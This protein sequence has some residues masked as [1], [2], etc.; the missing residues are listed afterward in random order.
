MKTIL[1]TG[2]TGFIGSWLTRHFVQNHF[3]V[4]AHGSSKKSISRLK[5]QLK[6]DGFTD[7]PITYWIQD[8]QNEK[9]D[10]PDLTHINYI[11]HCAALTSVREGTRENY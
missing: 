10:F 6:E 11:I 4:Y 9:W 7:A 3:E 2:A 5:R 8:F 1:I